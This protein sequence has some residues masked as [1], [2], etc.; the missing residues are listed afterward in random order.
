M[1][2][3]ERVNIEIN[4][5]TAGRGNNQGQ[6]TAAESYYGSDIMN[7]QPRDGSVSRYTFEPRPGRALSEGVEFGNNDYLGN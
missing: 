4:Q 7:I 3:G 1:Q 5:L 6:P 2:E